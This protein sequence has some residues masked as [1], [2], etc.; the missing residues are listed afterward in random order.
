MGDFI[1]PLTSIAEAP[2]DDTA[3]DIVLRSCDGV[4][5]C[6][7]KIVL[8]LASPFFKDM[9]SL[10]VTTAME[11]TDCKS[12]PVIDLSEHSQTV[13]RL[14]RLCYPIS[15]PVITELT[16]VDDAL[17]AAIKYQMEEATSIL[18]ALLRTFAPA[19]PLEVYVIACRL[20]LEP[21][22][23]EAARRWR[24][25]CPT[26]CARISGRSNLPEWT[27][28]SVGAS[29]VPEMAKISAGSLFRLLHFVRT[30]VEP[31]N[32]LEAGSD[33][34]PTNTP[35]GLTN[36]N[37]VPKHSFHY[38]DADIILRSSDG[39][40]FRVHKVIISLAS[41]D[42]VDNISNTQDALPVVTVPVNGRILAK[43]LK[44]CYPV[45]DSDLDDLNTTHAV[46]QAAMKYKITKVIQQ[47]K[48][49]LMKQVKEAP[50]R[51]YFIAIQY[52]WKEEAIEAARCAANQRIENVY[53]P[54]ME[55]TS[56]VDYHCLLTF[57]HNYR[58]TIAAITSDYE[59][60]QGEAW[61]EF[62]DC[63][64]GGY[65]NEVAVP[66]PIAGPIVQRELHMYKTGH[67]S[68]YSIP[69]VR[70]LIDESHELEAKLR[71]ALSTV[72]RAYCLGGDYL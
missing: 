51:G 54:E 16:G 3:A 57:H 67:R 52:G 71:K 48:K 49:Q 38:E 61:G 27:N 46:L 12:P 42:L 10:P 18:T 4:D 34:C 70:K 2:F 69:D 6:V 9:F 14:L 62:F 5:F 32:F 24:D 35:N 33:S 68:R 47:A 36:E 22:A 1:K 37:T 58:S 31:P 65:V 8:A 50:L 45:G 19:E 20:Q 28:T 13:D 60:I 17:E 44:I 30:G 26:A 55:S 63:S 7:Y 56:A 40:D 21:E 15:D 64:K 41:T 11:Q 53:I 43:L 23:K 72:S 66:M 29:F 25:K 39:V 59:T